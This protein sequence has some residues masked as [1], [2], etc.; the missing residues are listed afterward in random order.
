MSDPIIYRTQFSIVLRHTDAAGVLF[1]PRL[2]E[3]AHEVTEELLVQIGYPIADMVAGRLHHLPIVQAVAE[4]HLP[5]RLGDR[6]EV[7][8]ALH[9][10]GSRSVGFTCSFFAEGG[11]LAARTRVDHAAIDPKER[12]VCDLEPGFKRALQDLIAQVQQD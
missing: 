7:A 6:Y 2:M 1:Y 12:A 8:V 5:M 4:Y 11:V 10:L 3:I 9:K